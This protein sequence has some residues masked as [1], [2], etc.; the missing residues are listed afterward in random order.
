MPKSI[1]RFSYPFHSGLK[2]SVFAVLSFLP[3]MA[4]ASLV[5]SGNFSTPTTAAW[6]GTLP[7][8]SGSDTEHSFAFATPQLD[9]SRN[10]TSS[11]MLPEPPTIVAG[12]LLLL[13][14]GASI[15][16]I[17]RKQKDHV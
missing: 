7:Q 8:S 2:V 5:A 1:C 4:S 13:P 3:L 17:L 11:V 14:L 12:A 10:N 9:F 15:F 6:D 16:R